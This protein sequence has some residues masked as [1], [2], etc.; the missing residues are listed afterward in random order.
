MKTACF[1]VLLS[2]LP[3]ALTACSCDTIPFENALRADEI[4]FGELYK[5]ET[6]THHY[7]NTK[8]YLTDKNEKHTAW[9]YYFKVIKK[10]KGNQ[11][12]IAI[13]TQIETTC[14]FP[15]DI[16]S[17][18]YLVYSYY[19]HENNFISD[20]KNLLLY[21]ESNTYLCTRNTRIYGQDDMDWFDN[22]TTLLN[23]KF[24]QPIKLAS[25]KNRQIGLSAGLAIFL[26]AGFAL[27]R[28]WKKQQTTQSPAPPPPAH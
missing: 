3:I 28:R 13:V 5:I 26:L 22:D 8:T 17:Q 7:S 19:I 11:N 25:Y 16:Y 4:F 10:W 15:F 6:F 18:H 21:K 12:D 27:I 14:A 23:Q 20:A 1:L 9:R 2:I 24:P